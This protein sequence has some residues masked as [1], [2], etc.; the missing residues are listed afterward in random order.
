M[1]RAIRIAKAEQPGPVHLDF[2]KDTAED[3][4]SATD[5]SDLPRS[6]TGRATPE[7]LERA[8][9]AIRAARFPLVAVGLTMNRAGAT[10]ALRR[11]HW[12]PWYP[13]RA[14]TSNGRP[15]T[16][17]SRRCQ[18]PFVTDCGLKART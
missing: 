2:P 17:T 11:V 14:L 7:L 9:A 1:R 5:A 16:R 3:E 12:P 10:E 13:A 18:P 8:E 6:T 15:L 4:S